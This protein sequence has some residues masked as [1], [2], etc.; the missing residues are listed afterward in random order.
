MLLNM[1]LTVI[2]NVVGVL[3]MIPKGLVK[4]LRNPWTSGD[5]PDDSITEIGQNTE[6]SPGDLR[7]FCC[8]SNSSEK[9]STNFDG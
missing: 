2:S 6:E 3:G 7:K 4:G 8:H 5:H 1:K 9:S